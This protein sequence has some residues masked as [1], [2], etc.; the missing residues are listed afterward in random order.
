MQDPEFEATKLI[1][2]L[3]DQLAVIRRD[4]IEGLVWP[5]YLDLPGGQ[6]EPGESAEE[7]VLRETQEELGL[8]LTKADLIWR[9]FYDAPVRAWF[10]AAHLPAACADDVQFGDEGQYWALV[11]AQDFVQAR[12]AVPHF[13][14]RVQ[15]YVSCVSGL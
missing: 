12:D 1:L 7:C 10:F 14:G 2:F 3:G 5:G 4:D 13:R 11:P 8:V 6:R 9:R 15:D